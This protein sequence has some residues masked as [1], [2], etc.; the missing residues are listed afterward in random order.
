MTTQVLL[1]TLPNHRF[2]VTGSGRFAVHGKGN[3]PDEAV[4]A[5]REAARK[6]QIITVELTDKDSNTFEPVFATENE[7]SDEAWDD[8]LQL[9]E[10]QRQ[11]DNAHFNVVNET[12]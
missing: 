11:E 1:E 5:F 10:R 2:R 3:T 9:I 6:A 12:Q 8:F 4:N 7:I